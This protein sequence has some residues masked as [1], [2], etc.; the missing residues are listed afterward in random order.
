MDR[1]RRDRDRRGRRAV[2]RRRRRR[3]GSHVAFGA[4]GARCRGAGLR[5]ALRTRVAAVDR[6]HRRECRF[7]R[8]RG[9]AASFFR[10]GIVRRACVVFARAPWRDCG[11]RGRRPRCVSRCGGR[12]ARVRMARRSRDGVGARC[13]RRSRA[14]AFE[15]RAV[16][17]ARV[18]GSSRAR[19]S[20]LRP[21]RRCGF[22]PY[23]SR[24]L[25]RSRSSSRRKLP[26]FRRSRRTAH[27][28]RLRREARSGV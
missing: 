28:E 16:R 14:V 3:G 21:M 8:R 1:A 12:L 17:L 27:R 23:R 4:G 11:L 6:R 25:Q 5:S 20:V 26:P 10:Y 22:P 2:D 15:A 7:T 9:A 19:T 24:S 13:V 18:R